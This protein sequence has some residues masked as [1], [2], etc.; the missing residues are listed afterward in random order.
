MEQAKG[1]SKVQ[2]ETHPK[3]RI[4]RKSSLP[5]LALLRAKNEGEKRHLVLFVFVRRRQHLKVTRKDAR[6]ITDF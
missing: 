2:M 5:P 3:R 1:I 6:P 4:A